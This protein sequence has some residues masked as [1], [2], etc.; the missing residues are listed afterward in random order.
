MIFFQT[1]SWELFENSFVFFTALHESP[2]FLIEMFVKLFQHGSLLSHRN[3]HIIYH[4]VQ[5]PQDKV[6]NAD[7]RSVHME[8]DSQNLHVKLC[9]CFSP[10]NRYMISGD[11][12]R[13]MLCKQ[14]TES[15]SVYNFKGGSCICMCMLV[16]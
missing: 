2:L 11:W 1:Y 10:I 14:M 16:L 5:C 15:F 8:R 7:G 6:E 9:R 13:G 12:G 4:C 3:V